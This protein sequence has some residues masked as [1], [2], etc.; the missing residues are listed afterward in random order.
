MRLFFAIELPQ[1]IQ[2]AL[3]ASTDRLRLSEAR[4]GWV[5]RENLHLTLQF[6]GKVETSWLGTLEDC[7]SEVAARHSPTAIPLDVFG[8]FPSSAKPRVIWAGP[9]EAPEGILLLQADLT[10]ALAKLGFLGDERFFPHV[11]IGRVRERDRQ[12]QRGLVQ[13]LERE[14]PPGLSVPVDHVSLL[15]SQRGPNGV[16]YVN[17]FR[18]PIA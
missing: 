16:R 12:R 8:A 4:M 17:A 15:Q 14:S 6:L 13:V 18:C 7:A 3:E 1:A 11:T 10:T 2:E 5:R 9:C